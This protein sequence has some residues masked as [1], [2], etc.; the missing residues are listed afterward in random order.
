M[1][2][3]AMIAVV[4]FVIASMIAAGLGM[5]LWFAADTASE[6]DFD[7]TDDPSSSV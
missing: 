5:L 4:V 3:L 1:T 7:S 2:T 6:S